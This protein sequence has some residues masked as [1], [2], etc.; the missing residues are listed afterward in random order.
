[1]KKIIEL[2]ESYIEDGTATSFC[3]L[4]DAIKERKILEQTPITE[5]WLKEHGWEKVGR[6]YE[7]QEGIWVQRWNFEDWKKGRL[8]ILDTPKYDGYTWKGIQLTSVAK[9]LDAC[10][11]C[12]IKID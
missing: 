1:M 2:A 8:E 10:D 7:W 9:L 11:L 12:G 6:P 3:R 4:E 5:D